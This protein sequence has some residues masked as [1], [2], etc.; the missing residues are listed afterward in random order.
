APAMGM[1][2]LVLVGA[3]LGLAGVPTGHRPGLLIWFGVTAAGWVVALWMP[4]SEGSDTA[5]VEEEPV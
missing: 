1:A 5:E 2:V 4:G 3:A